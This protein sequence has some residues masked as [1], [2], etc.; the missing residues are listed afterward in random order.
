MTDFKIDEKTL[1][2]CLPAI[3]KKNHFYVCSA[4]VWLAHIV[5]FVSV[6]N[7]WQMNPYDRSSAF[8]KMSLK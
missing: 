5:W 8:G 6:F 2:F 4:D 1:Y 7:T 3:M